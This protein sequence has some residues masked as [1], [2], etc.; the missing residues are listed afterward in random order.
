MHLAI[1]IW[2]ILRSLSYTID[3]IKNQCLQPITNMGHTYE[4]F[5]HTYNF[6][7]DYQNL[8][9]NE[10]SVKLNFSEWKALNPH[11][12]FIENQDKF[13]QIANY[14]AYE[15]LGDPW[16]NNFQSQ[17]NHIRALHSL[18]HLARKVEQ[19][20]LTRAIDGIIYLRPDVLYINELPV[21]LFENFKN[22]LFVPDFHRSCKSGEFNDRMAMGDTKS[23]ITYGKRYEEALNYSKKKKLHSEKFTYDYLKNNNINVLEMP[24]RFQRVRADGSIHVRDQKLLTPSQ[25]FKS[26]PTGATPYK[27]SIFYRFF[28]CGINCED[29]EN[30]YCSPNPRISYKQYLQFVE[31]YEKNR[32]KI[33]ILQKNENNLIF[34]QNK[35][36]VVENIG[37]KNN[38]DR[39]NF[40]DSINDINMYNNNN[41]NQSNR[42]KKTRFRTNLTTSKQHLNNFTYMDNNH[43]KN[44]YRK[45]LKYEINKRRRIK[46]RNFKIYINNI[47]NNYYNS[48]GTIHNIN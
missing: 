14:E 37:F 6:T 36:V 47:N 28:Y 23:A 27:T 15:T 34:V 25:Q 8:R 5:I 18:D 41:N 42:S 32:K 33:I 30:M 22:T 11:Y 2:G 16:K 20:S 21:L 44:K 13:D 35:S 4:I 17:K 12:I 40:Y 24:F 29:H 7:G 1:C 43:I 9:N 48:S 26:S 45:T 3:S 46:E 39:K 10:K 31:N 38:S 19:V